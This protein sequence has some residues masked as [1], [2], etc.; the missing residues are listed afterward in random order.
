MTDQTNEVNRQLLATV[1]SELERVFVGSNL[2]CWEDH[3]DQ[4]VVRMR[5][6]LIR[7]SQK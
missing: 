1:G 3:K 6:E 7:R 5:N 4:R 2:R